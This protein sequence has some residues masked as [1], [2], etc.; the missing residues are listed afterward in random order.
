MPINRHHECFDTFGRV[1]SVD[2]A[3]RSVLFCLQK[4]FVFFHSDCVKFQ[5]AGSFDLG[6]VNMAVWDEKDV[7]KFTGFFPGVPHHPD[8]T[9]H[10]SIQAPY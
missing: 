9:P 8:S 7:S 1:T 4:C 2:F 3:S 5:C 6:I 10:R